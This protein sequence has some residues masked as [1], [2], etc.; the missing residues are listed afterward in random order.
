MWVA[1]AALSKSKLAHSL[2]VVIYTGDSVEPS[3]MLQRAKVRARNFR[4]ALACKYGGRL[5]HRTVLTWT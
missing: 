3:A 2:R 4:R 1:L 5:F